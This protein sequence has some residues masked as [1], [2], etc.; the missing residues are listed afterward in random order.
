MDWLWMFGF[1]FSHA[2]AIAAYE[3]TSLLHKSL[4][5]EVL[6]YDTLIK[7]D[8]EKAP[9]YPNPSRIDMQLI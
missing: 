7:R 6:L 2:P 5:A 8:D 9:W 1:A 4:E 3:L